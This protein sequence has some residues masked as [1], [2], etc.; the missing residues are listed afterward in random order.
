MP[1]STTKMRRFQ[2]ST[3]SPIFEKRIR[4]TKQ[5]TLFKHDN[6]NKSQYGLLSMYRYGGQGIF[7]QITITE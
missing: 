5:E 3:Y 1:E 4:N 2:W 7:G 6:Q